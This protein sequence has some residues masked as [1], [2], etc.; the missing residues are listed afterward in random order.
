MLL[1]VNCNCDESCPCRC[2]ELVIFDWFELR[3]R[4]IMKLDQTSPI[5]ELCYQGP[6]MRYN[7]SHRLKVLSSSISCQIRNLHLPHIHDRIACVHM[8]ISCLTKWLVRR[9]EGLSHVL[10]VVN[11]SFQWHTRFREQRATKRVHDGT[12]DKAPLAFSN[13]RDR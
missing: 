13:A 9:N 6:T 7:V 12:N 5:W 8:Q 3:F 2:R 4:A 10:F 11:S 1:R